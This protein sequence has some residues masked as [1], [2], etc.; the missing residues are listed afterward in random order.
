MLKLLFGNINKEKAVEKL[1]RPFLAWPDAVIEIEYGYDILNDSEF[2]KKAL[3]EV[4][5]CDVPLRNVARDIETGNT[6]SFDRVSTGV[7]TLWLMS[8]VEEGKYAFMSSWIG[9]NCYQLMLDLSKTRDIYLY[10]DSEFLTYADESIT[11]EFEDLYT[12]S[13]VKV[14]NNEGFDYMIDKEYNVWLG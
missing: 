14:D 6:H 7:K 2:F 13:I 9:E 11:G 3:L 1:G 4:D 5:K 12:G 10:D 8:H